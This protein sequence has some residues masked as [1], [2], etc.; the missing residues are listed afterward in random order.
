MPEKSVKIMLS[1]PIYD[2]SRRS[3]QSFT[4]YQQIVEQV[5]RQGTKLDC[6]NLGNGFFTKRGT[7]YPDLVNAV[8]MAERAY[9][10]EKKGYDAFIIGCAWDPGLREARSLVRIPVISPTESTLMLTWQLGRKLCALDRRPAKALEYGDL[11]HKYGI[12]DRLVSVRCPPEFS[13]MDDFD[14]VY[15]GEERQKEF[16]RI[17][18]A[19]MRRAI[20]EDHAEVLWYACTVGASVLTLH[21]IYEID[22]VS[23]INPFVAALKMAEVMVDLQR[24]YGTAVCRSSVYRS[25]AAGWE[26]E[27]QI[28]VD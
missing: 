28:P 23:L 10:A 26:K 22:G 18:T 21:N 5:A 2:P 12:A 8:G 16:V 24:A 25:P 1:N 3:S 19:E 14:L 20:V 9:E 15:G 4:W 6:V 11:L 13:S 17:V 7:A 27:R